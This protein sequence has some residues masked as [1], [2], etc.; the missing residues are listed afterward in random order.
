V[1]DDAVVEPV[2]CKLDEV[3]DGLRRV[4]VEELDRDGTVIR[5][6]SGGRQNGAA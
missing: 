5:M 4:L 1:E 2:A 6:Q 3:L